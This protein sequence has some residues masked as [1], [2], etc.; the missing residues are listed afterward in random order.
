MPIPP[1]RI[2][3]IFDCDDTLAKDTTS[4]LLTKFGANPKE[5]YAEAAALVRDGW[6]PALAYLTIILKESKSKGRLQGFAKSKLTELANDSTD[7][8]YP[9]TED[10]FARLRAVVEENERYKDL[11]IQIKFYIISAGIEEFLCETPVGKAADMVW[12]SGFDYDGKGK[13]QAIRNA[14]SFTEK[15]RFLFCINKG[16]ESQ[17]R[18]T[19]YIVNSSE[20]HR[21]TRAVPFSNMIYVGDGPSDIP[22]MSVVAQYGGFAIGM[23]GDNVERTWEVG[24]GRRANV[25]I[26]PD[27]REES[28]GY[29]ILR[30]AVLRI[31]EN[32][33]KQWNYG[34]TSFPKY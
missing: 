18:N 12:G 2:A 29:P 32:I 11:G 3:V 1:N 15:T 30:E 9:G 24:F 27:Y 20:P 4:W 33:W 6:D 17:A 16:V 34:I 23:L 22:C 14:M 7:L 26:P 10:L 21:E 25:T 19:P 8:F 28:S 31:A 13:P 5:I